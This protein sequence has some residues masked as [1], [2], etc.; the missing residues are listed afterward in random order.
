MAV[1]VA[2]KYGKP[3]RFDQLVKFW[4]SSDYYHVAIVIDGVWYSAHQSHGTFTAV[5]RYAPFDWDFL[6]IP[7]EESNKFRMVRFAVNELGCG[8]DWWGLIFSQIFFLRREDPNRWFC[9][10]FVLEILK[11]GY[12]GEGAE[13]LSPGGLFVHLSEHYD[14]VTL[15][16][17]SEVWV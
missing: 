14:L 3:D 7:V 5:T 6:E 15:G 4:T 1:Y 16:R 17:D 10:E 12:V 8:Y 13:L 9:S 2:F 11:H